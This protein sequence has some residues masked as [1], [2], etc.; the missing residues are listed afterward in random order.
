MKWHIP[1]AVTV[2]NGVLV[3][4][5]RSFRFLAIRKL[6]LHSLSRRG[7][8]AERFDPPSWTHGMRRCIY[9]NWF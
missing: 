2:R 6:F 5:G 7:V 8:S 1:D 4:F 3:G 9:P